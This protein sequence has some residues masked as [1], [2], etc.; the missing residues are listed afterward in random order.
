[1]IVETQCLLPL[2][3]PPALA[4]LAQA[5]RLSEGGL[6]AASFEHNI[7]VKRNQVKRTEAA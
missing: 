6:T 1:M 7:L 4:R 3:L 2:R 5:H